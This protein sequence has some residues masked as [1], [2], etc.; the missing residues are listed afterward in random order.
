MPNLSASALQNQP[1]DVAWPNRLAT[2]FI[3]APFTPLLDSVKA[4]IEGAGR[5]VAQEP[6][7]RGA[8]VSHAVRLYLELE[9]RE[10][11]SRK[12]AGHT[13]G[14]LRVKALDV[15]HALGWSA[16]TYWRALK[17][18]RLAEVLHVRRIG[19]WAKN[20][21]S[22]VGSCHTF[23]TQLGMK[24]KVLNQYHYRNKKKALRASQEP[25]NP[26]AACTHD[27]P[28]RHSALCY[29]KKKSETA[30]LSPGQIELLRRMGYA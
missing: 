1:Q 20:R 25:A 6:W 5:R 23:H 15:R 30:N 7:F 26:L 2:R 21:P 14:T 24:H 13:A 3:S 8:T 18:L 17:L 27:P 28:C 11:A 4:A 9:Q 16:M 22:C 12:Q 10:R 19:G 29:W